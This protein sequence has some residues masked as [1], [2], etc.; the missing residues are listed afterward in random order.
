[1]TTAFVSIYD[2]AIRE[3]VRLEDKLALVEL[4]IRELDEHEARTG[5]GWPKSKAELLLLKA[6]LIDE[7][8]KDKGD[9][10]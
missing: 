10:A 3:A 1:M 2:E 9:A 5:L 6:R 8:N 7:Q 4:A